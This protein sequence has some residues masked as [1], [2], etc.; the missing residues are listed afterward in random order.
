MPAIEGRWETRLRHE[1]R[2]GLEQTWFE[3]QVDERWLAAYRLMPEEGYAWPVELRLLPGRIDEPRRPAGQPSRGAE[4]A[5]I[6]SSLLREL[7]VPE[8]MKLAR[9]A[10]GGEAGPERI[11]ISGFWGFLKAEE[12]PPSG[13]GRKAKPDQYYAS[14][15][16]RYVGL[17]EG[18]SRQPFKEL[19]EES[20]GRGT[21]YSVEFFQNEINEARRRGLLTSAGPGKAGGELTDK[22]RRLLKQNHAEK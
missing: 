11:E 5:Q 18:G 12:R 13:A 8:H 14:L 16:V 6:T 19:E 22:A 3:V 2:G 17:V 1:I 15:A 10:L 20:Q 7:R 4:P 21:F 9:E